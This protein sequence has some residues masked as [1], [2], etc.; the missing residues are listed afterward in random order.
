MK[1]DFFLYSLN[2]TDSNEGYALVKEISHQEPDPNKPGSGGDVIF[3]SLNVTY[4]IN[5]FY[6][7]NPDS[8]DFIIAAFNATDVLPIEEASY[9]K[10]YY[11]GYYGLTNYCAFIEV[12]EIDRS[13]QKRLRQHFGKALHS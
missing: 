1:Y 4:I 5:E 11:L 9:F 8:L 12:S 10:G 3:Y 7:N 6:R 2:I 13:S